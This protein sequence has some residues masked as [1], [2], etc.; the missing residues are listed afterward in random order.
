MKLR[1]T[2]SLDSALAGR[3]PAVLML[4]VTALTVTACGGG[5]SGGGGQMPTP[6]NAAPV[7]ALIPSQTINQDTP[8]AALGFAVNDDGGSDAV[9]VSVASSNAAIV[10]SE[11]LVLAG[12]GVNRTIT[13]TP[14]ED[15]TGQV[16]ITVKA[17]DA[18]GLVGTST[19][20]VTVAAVERSLTAYTNST[21]AQGE[22]ETPAQ[23]SG[24]TFVQDA[25]AETTFDPLL[26]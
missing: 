13:V 2:N 4:A 18:Q 5:G 22:N 3:V 20:G 11:G 23:V 6:Q 7:V 17:Q 16:T 8:T 19:F 1:M 21:F 9:T 24:F 26:Q 25:D 15:A 12:S 10:P 14:A